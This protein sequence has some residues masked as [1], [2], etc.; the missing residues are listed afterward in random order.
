MNITL[1]SSIKDRI[2]VAQKKACD[3][4]TR[5]QKG[6]DEMIEHKSDGAFYY[7]DRI[8]VSLKSDSSHIEVLEVNARGIRNPVGHKYGL[9]PSD[10]RSDYNSSVRCAPFEA[11]YGRKCRYLI[12]W[13]EVGEGQLI[14][15]ELVQETTK[16]ISQNVVR[17][18]KKEK[19]APRFVRPF[20]IVNEVGFVAYRLRLPEELNGVHDTFHVSNLKECVADPTLQVPFDEIQVDAKLNFVE[21]PVEFLEREFKKLKRSRITIVKVRWNLKRG[22]EFTW[23]H[24]DQ[25]KL[26]YRHL[27]SAS[28]N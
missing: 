21:E 22:P 2:L 26:K 27:F 20:K 24:E 3:E 8:W 18:G 14:G 15:P 16:K 19:L 1:Q 9:P 23:E 25:M 6:L 28:S 7:L 17:F 11:L 12:M 10:R 4:F 5:L 13:A